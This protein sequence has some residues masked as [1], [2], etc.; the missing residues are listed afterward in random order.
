MG[1]KLGGSL[2]QIRPTA[3]AYV[4]CMRQSKCTGTGY[5]RDSASELG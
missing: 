5:G 1:I 4:A 3:P 2:G